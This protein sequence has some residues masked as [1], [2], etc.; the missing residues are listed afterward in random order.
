MLSD[1]ITEILIEVATSTVQIVILI[2]IAVGV[3]W[4]LEQINL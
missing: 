2:A 3:C 1:K 4:L